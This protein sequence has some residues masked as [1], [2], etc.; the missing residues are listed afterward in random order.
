MYILFYIHRANKM[1][2][3]PAT[4]NTSCCSFR[5]K[6]SRLSPGFLLQPRKK[7]TNKKP[8]WRG[9]AC[10]PWCSSPCFFHGDEAETG[11]CRQCRGGQATEKPPRALAEKRPEIICGMLGTAVPGWVGRSCGGTDRG[12][13]ELALRTRVRFVGCWPGIIK[14]LGCWAE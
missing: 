14:D 2:T 5:M 1:H 13:R 7:T 6:T 9:H 12:D 4:T 3:T 8:T 11:L 10:A